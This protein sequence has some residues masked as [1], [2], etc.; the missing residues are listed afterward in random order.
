MTRNPLHTRSA[1]MFYGARFPIV[2]DNLSPDNR[3][4]WDAWT[5]EQKA[6][7]VARLVHKGVLI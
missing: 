6:L 1:R 3:V 2:R 4:K 7:F 5:Y